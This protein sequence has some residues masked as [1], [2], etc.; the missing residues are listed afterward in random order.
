[1]SGTWIDSAPGGAANTDRDQRL[2]ERLLGLYRIARDY[3][4][5]FYNSWLRNYRLVNNRTGA[6]GAASW[7]PQPRDS[8]IYPILSALVGWMTDQTTTIEFVPSED[9]DN[10]YYNY[11]SS[12]ASDLE[13]V[14][15]ASWEANAYSAQVKLCIWDALTYSVG[16]GK[17]VWDNNRAG[18]MGDA[19]LRR[20]DPWS[21]YPD[22]NA[23]SM[24]DAEYFVEVR[25]YSRS[26]IIRRFPDA[27]TWL[28]YGHDGEQEIDE[29]PRLNE[30]GVSPPKTNP[31]NIPQS[32]RWP[33][34]SSAPG[35]FG[36][37]S[38]Q[39]AL[40]DPLPGYVTYEFWLR[41]ND[42]WYDDQEDIPKELR[43]ED[44]P[45]KKV[46]VRWRCI[47][48]C[49]GHILM[50]VYADEM[51][52]HK[53]HPYSRYAFD[54]LGEFYGVALVEHMAFPQIYINR[55]LTALQQNAELVGNPI[56]IEA[57]NSGLNRVG[58]IN[59]P[60][61]RLTLNGAAAMQNKPDWLQPPSMPPQVMD[62]VNFWIDRL[63]NISGL[64]ST[65]KGQVPQQRSAEGTVQTAQE[66]AMVRVRSALAN[67]EWFL[68]DQGFKVAD[69]ICNF[70][71]EPRII[72]V[73]G[74]DG[75]KTAKSLHYSHF[76]IHSD[77]NKLVPLKYIVMVNAG[78]DGP[79]S[80]AA[81]VNEADK[82]FTLGVVDDEYVLQIRQT[83][84]IKEI[85]ARKYY[86]MQQGLM[87]GGPGQRQRAGRQR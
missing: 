9:P 82:L 56:F 35:Y 10:D 33:G 38:R 26:E 68:R 66:S 77:D 50:D 73:V 79:T 32:G 74:P 7:M 37:N 75:A 70:Y 65:T 52:G 14:V 64:S 1:M 3:K 4:R 47:V 80:R 11:I 49:N 23:T 58:I 53:E 12:L 17:A 76:L 21:F 78:S 87:G 54:D 62:L 39:K 83:K 57:A 84:G 81:R 85:L 6:L 27:E 15:H 8:E 24:E 60:G 44:T 59:R 69:L 45:I 41:E 72:A 51:W 42:I 71:T 20:V 30:D 29:R 36:Q 86:K 2:V 48:L 16:I 13:D 31:G 61:Q 55:L 19:L 25:R 34:S 5:Q 63:E 67:L 46:D 18:G 28:D 22:A 40:W 43:D